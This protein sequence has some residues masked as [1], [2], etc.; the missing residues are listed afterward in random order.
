MLF[1]K[2][3]SYS[4]DARR[5]LVLNNSIDRDTL[6]RIL[7]EDN[8][9]VMH[10]LVYKHTSFDLRVIYDHIENDKALLTKMPHYFMIENPA[11]SEEDIDI[12]YDWVVA[13]DILDTSEIDSVPMRYTDWSVT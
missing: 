2:P 3:N 4:K 1:I 6:N 12:W 5:H 11:L 8:D 7:N 13:N 10:A 9:E